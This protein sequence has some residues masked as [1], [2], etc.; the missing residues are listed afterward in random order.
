MHR[1]KAPIT[2]THCFKDGSADPAA[3]T[4]PAAIITRLERILADALKK[5]EGDPRL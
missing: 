5:R 3:K 4:V 2:V 1:V